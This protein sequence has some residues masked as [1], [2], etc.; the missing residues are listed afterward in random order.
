MKVTF[1]LLAAI[2]LVYVLYSAAVMAY[3]YYQVMDIVS[4]TVKERAGG[5]HDGR[6]ARIKQDILKKASRDGVTLN[7]RDVSVTDEN[8]TLHVRVSWSYPAVVYKGEPA[9]SIPLSYDRSFEIRGG[10]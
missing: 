9:L 6:A 10:P 7:E 2:G 5:E 4:E 1:G 3:S 8:R